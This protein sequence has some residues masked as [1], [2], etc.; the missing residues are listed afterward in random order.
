MISQS[1][2]GN[3]AQSV[4]LLPLSLPKLFPIFSKTFLKPLC[5]LCLLSSTFGVQIM[6]GQKSVQQKKKI[7]MYTK[8]CCRLQPETAGELPQS[9]SNCWIWWYKFLYCLKHVVFWQ[10]YVVDTKWL[11]SWVPEPSNSFNFPLSDFHNVAV[12]CLCIK[13]SGKLSQHSPKQNKSWFYQNKTKK[14]KSIAAP[15]TQKSKVLEFILLQVLLPIIP[16]SS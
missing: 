7:W 16:L 14:H 5:P 6:T 2:C 8:D 11:L 15:P 4:L 3:R 9:V 1:C 12:F 10:Q 13:A